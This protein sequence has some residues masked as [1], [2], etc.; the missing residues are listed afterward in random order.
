MRA[1]VPTAPSGAATK[2]AQV[3]RVVDVVGAG[4]GLGDVDGTAAGEGLGDAA[5]GEGDAGNA[6]EGL[7]GAGDVG[8]GD[9]EGDAG[10]TVVLLAAGRSQMNCLF[11]NCRARAAKCNARAAE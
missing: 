8:V 2:A 11:T 4:E 1:T 9:G 3:A 6:G 10:V 5:A 7:R